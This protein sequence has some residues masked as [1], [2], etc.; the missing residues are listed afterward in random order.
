MYLDM[1]N[2]AQRRHNQD[3]MLPPSHSVLNRNFVNK[4]TIFCRLS[5]QKRFV[6]GTSMS[7][8]LMLFLYDCLHRNTHLCRPNHYGNYSEH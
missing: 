3:R 6:I 4:S 1:Y 7:H 5:P 2:H 8:L